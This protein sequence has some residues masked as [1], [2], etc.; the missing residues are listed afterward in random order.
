[1]LLSPHV[2]NPDGTKFFGS[3]TKLFEYMAMER[4]IVASALEQIGDILQPAYRAD[5]LAAVAAADDRVAVVTTPGSIEELVQG[6][7]FLVERPALRAALGTNARR[8]VKA[9]YT[10]SANVDALVARCAALS[11]QTTAR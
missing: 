11:R 6:I 9:R 8:L 7:R 1:M 5:A 4:G 10:W 2:P 3:P